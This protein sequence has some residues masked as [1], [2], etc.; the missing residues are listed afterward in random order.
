[1]R[2]PAHAPLVYFVRDRAGFL[3]IGTT[4]DFDRRLRQLARLCRG[5]VDVL[6]TL[7]GGRDVE[8]SL[9]ARFASDAVHGEYFTPSKALLGFIESV[10]VAQRPKPAVE[11]VVSLFVCALPPW[12]AVALRESLPT[13]GCVKR[14]GATAYAAGAC[15]V[16]NGAGVLPKTGAAQEAA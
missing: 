3:K 1:M 7:P 11:N 4:T 9:H 12:V 5:K 15:K 10:K 16:C 2:R 14:V 13:C 8:Q 6:A